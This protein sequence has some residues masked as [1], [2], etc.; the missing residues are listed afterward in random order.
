MKIILSALLLLACC[1]LLSAVGVD[2][3]EPET[4]LEIIYPKPDQL[5]SAIDSTFVFGN[6]QGDFNRKHDCLSI[7]GQTIKV[8]SDGGFLAFLPVTPGEFQFQ[9]RALRLVDT[10]LSGSTLERFQL[11][12]EQIIPVIIPKPDKSLAED[13]LQILGDYRPPSG[14]LTLTTGDV[15]HIRFQG[16]PGMFAWAAIPGLIDSIPMSEMEPRQQSYWGEA[17]FG[18]GAIPDSVLIHGIYSG[19]YVVPESVSVINARIIYNIATPPHKYIR[20]L[21]APP[22]DNPEDQ[23]LLK[24]VAMPEG[25]ARTSSYRVS[26]NNPTFPFTVRFIDSTQTVRYGPRLGYFSIYQPQGVEAL[27]VGQNA[28]W[29]RLKLSH[30]QYA[31]AHT[32][33]V[34]PLPKGVLPPASRLTAIR[35]F[36]FEDHVLIEFPLAGKHPF[37]I[38]EDSRR[39]LR[40]QLFGVTT[41][42]DWIRYDSD[43][44]LVELATW[45]QP[46]DGLYELKLTLGT[47]IWGYDTYYE[48]NTFYLKLYKPPERIKYLWGKTIV[49]DPGHSSDAGAIGP[50]GLTEAEANLMIALA[51]RREL[52]KHHA[53]VVMTRDDMS[54]VALYDR[55]I[56]AKLANADLFVSV[57]NNALPDGVNPFNNHGVSTYYYHPHSINLARSIQSELLK[58]TGMPDFGLY[59]GNFA[60]NRPTQYPAVL[61]ECA[62]MMIPEQEALLKTSRF[63]NKIAR[64]I[65][66]GIEDCLRQYDECNH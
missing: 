59:H 23:R 16:T 13:T 22:S 66:K 52:E 40:L 9:V 38:Y 5:V 35:L 10:E 49:I 32:G 56:I 3:G 45:S 63:Q 7:N 4:R 60:V 47:D 61:V 15:L 14:D 25:L 18:A 24:L 46:E 20:P 17:V 11:L 64:A 53:K 1:G 54:H 48:G 21:I 26:F 19:R 8:H 37:R 43:E 57:H 51:L 62:F 27:V 31:W 6:V 42:T 39:V 34:M 2:A 50:T 29:Y 36:S 41:N 33:S 44:S 65:T 28:D 58:A 30:S 55:P 12:A